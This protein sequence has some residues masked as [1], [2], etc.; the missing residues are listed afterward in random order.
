MKAKKEKAP[1]KEKAPKKKGPNYQMIVSGFV[2]EVLSWPREMKIAK[3]L[4]ERCPNEDFWKA[5]IG[6]RKVKSLSWLLTTENLYLIGQKYAEFSKKSLELNSPTIYNLS[7][8]FGED[9][10]IGPKKPSLLD[11]VKN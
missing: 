4:F 2:P 8:K 9:K 10:P 1:R 3:K 11:F 5:L 7:E 6:W